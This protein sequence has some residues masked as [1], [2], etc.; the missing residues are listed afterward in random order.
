MN[1]QPALIDLN[2]EQI[3]RWDPKKK[4]K[5]F[6]S[7]EEFEREIQLDGKL[8]TS[9]VAAEIFQAGYLELGGMVYCLVGRGLPTKFL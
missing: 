5:T 8:D 7:P 4:E 1:Q 9:L 2:S 3:I 6:V